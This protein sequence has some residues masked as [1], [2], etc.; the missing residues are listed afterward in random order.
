MKEQIYLYYY[1]TGYKDVCDETISLMLNWIFQKFELSKWA[2]Y[3][4]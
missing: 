1:N 2:Y 4:A 3:G